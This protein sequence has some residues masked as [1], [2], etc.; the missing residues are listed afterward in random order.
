MKYFLIFL[1]ALIH[2]R[3]VQLICDLTDPVGVARNVFAGHGFWSLYDSRLLGPF[4][5]RLF[6]NDLGG[7]LL[8]TFVAALVGGWLAWQIGGGIQGLAI[9]HLAYGAVLHRMFYVWDILEPV[10]FAAFVWMVVSNFGWRWLVALFAVAIWNRQ[11]AEFVAL[12]MALEGALKRHRPLMISGVLCGLGGLLI[13]HQM[14]NCGTLAF[15]PNGNAW[16]NDYCQMRLW[17][18]ICSL[19]PEGGL[20]Q[21]L[22]VCI[23]PLYLWTLYALI[24]AAA[25][26]L[27]RS[28]HRALGIVYLC[29]LAIIPVFGITDETRS[30]EDFIPLLVM[31]ASTI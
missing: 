3:M 9:Y 25:I 19:V 13:M 21:N 7:F 11:S 23:T 22:G 24:A 30:L 10:I 18:N 17:P 14:Q 8:L 12:W 5:L 27:I 2:L 31:A 15:V 1:G 20:L 28:S 4:L 29:L 26:S 16:V 6:G